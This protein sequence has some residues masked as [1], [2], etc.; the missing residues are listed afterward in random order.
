[1][2]GNHHNNGNDR[3]RHHVGISNVIKRIRSRSGSRSRNNSTS[4]CGSTGSNHIVN[5]G[6]FKVLVIGSEGVGKTS[7]CRTYTGLSSND[8]DMCVKNDSI[9]YDSSIFIDRKNEEIEQ[10]DLEI[11]DCRRNMSSKER[12]NLIKRCDGF[13]LVYSKT[14]RQSFLEV[15]ELKQDIFHN[16]SAEGSGKRLTPAMLAVGNKSDLH[17]SE[18]VVKADD[19]WAL[20]IVHVDVSAKNNEGLQTAFKLVVKACIDSKEKSERW[21]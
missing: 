21:K 9:P 14:S 19:L 13:L 17:T 15:L 3:H 18:Y 10:Y 11:Y 5:H 6:E 4:S 16:W 8:N 2:F 12:R 20:D 1:M 7:I